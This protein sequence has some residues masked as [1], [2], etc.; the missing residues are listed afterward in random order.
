VTR[1]AGL[2]IILGV[3]TMGPTTAGFVDRLAGNLLRI[4][5]ARTGMSQ[6]RLA[7]AAGVAQSTI[8]RIE[9]GARQPSLP[10]LARIL[11]A[12][13]LE[14]RITLEAYDAH[15]DLLDAADARLTDAQRAARRAVQDKFAAALRAG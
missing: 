1:D 6:R 8:A 3:P 12:A 9:S 2:A 5:R 14:P 4:A 7:A 15:D 10:L 13:D 11:A